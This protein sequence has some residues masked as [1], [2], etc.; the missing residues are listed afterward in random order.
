MNSTTRAGSENY[1]SRSETTNLTSKEAS[2]IFRSQTVFT[3][4]IEFSKRSWSKREIS[5][6]RS[7]QRSR[8]TRNT[9]PTSSTTE[10]KRKTISLKYWVQQLP[11]N[12]KSQSRT[13]GSTRRKR[14]GRKYTDTPDKK[15]RLLTYSLKPQQKTETRS[16]LLK[17]S[18]PRPPPQILWGKH[19][20]TIPC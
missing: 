13:R 16:L 12:S 9:K 17:P 15:Q 4:S 19:G 11:F 2:R 18:S 3:K 7:I 14:T 5:S 20:P 6:K 1:L 10:T 8:T